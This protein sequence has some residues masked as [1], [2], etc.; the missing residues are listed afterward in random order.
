MVFHCD[1]TGCS[2][3][4]IAH[5]VPGT[6]QSYGCPPARVVRELG[7]NVVDPLG[8]DLTRELELTRCAC[9]RGPE[10]THYLL[11]GRDAGGAVGSMRTDGTIVDSIQA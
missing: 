5:W 6:H 1:S 10:W 3:G 7:W 4:S 2:N 8:P 9:A 11:S